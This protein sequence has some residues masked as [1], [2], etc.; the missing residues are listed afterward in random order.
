MGTDALKEG[1][2]LL[3][4][5]LFLGFEGEHQKS[6]AGGMGGLK[7]KIDVLLEILLAEDVP[8]GDLVAH[9]F[10]LGGVFCDDF[11][12]RIVLQEGVDGF[13]EGEEAPELL[14]IQGEQRHRPPMV[15]GNLSPQRID[16]IALPFGEGGV[17]QKGRNGGEEEQSGEEGEEE[18]L[19]PI[20]PVGD[21]E[22]E[23]DREAD[24]AEKEEEEAPKGFFFPN[25]L[26]FH[27]FS[28]WSK[29][30]RLTIL[31]IVGIASRPF[32]RKF[33]RCSRLPS[34]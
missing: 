8:Q 20:D 14:F 13:L 3:R 19:G 11:E 26:F 28:P 12:A 4:R 27:R 16:G 18:P 32:L 9:G 22:A 2:L 1:A 23:G 31:P 24:P 30:V 34:S 15:G 7:L 21:G 10:V 29:R 17:Q 6:A 25:A 5:V 33:R